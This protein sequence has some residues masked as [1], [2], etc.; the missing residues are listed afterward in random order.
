[1]RCDAMRCVR[2]RL[3]VELVRRAMAH[4]GIIPPDS[5]T[6]LLCF[7]ED[8][9]DARAIEDARAIDGGER[10]LARTLGLKDDW[11]GKSL[12]FTAKPEA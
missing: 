10:R 4:G 1:M 8:T 5:R 6:F 9:V 12:Y 7:L 3:C 2:A 11:I